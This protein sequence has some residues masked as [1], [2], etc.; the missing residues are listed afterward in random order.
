M[1]GCGLKFGNAK[2]S[3]LKAIVLGLVILSDLAGSGQALSAG[4]A[5]T[6]S[7]VSGGTHS[8]SIIALAELP[9]DFGPPSPGPTDPNGPFPGP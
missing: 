4:P 9:R 2:S 1:N 7:S 6:A 5:D 8:G 3:A